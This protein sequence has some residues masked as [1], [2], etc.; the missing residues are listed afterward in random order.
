MAECERCLELE[1]RIDFLEGVKG[2]AT[3]HEYLKRHDIK[4]AKSC[5]DAS[6]SAIEKLIE[7]I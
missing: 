7:G 1:T 3:F 2:Y 4:I 5:L 6:R